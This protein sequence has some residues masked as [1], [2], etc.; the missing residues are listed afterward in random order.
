MGAMA[1]P[2]TVRA[3]ETTTQLTFSVDAALLAELGER[4]VGEPHIALGELI[5]NGYDADATHVRIQFTGDA[6]IVEDDGHGMTFDEFDRLWMRVGSTHKHEQGTSRNRGRAL[7]GSKGVGRL[8]VQFLARRLTLQTCAGEEEVEATVFWPDAARPGAELVKTPVTVTRRPSQ[9]T[10]IDSPTGMRLVLAE[11]N[12]AWMSD[13][14][15]HLAQEIWT[16]QPPFRAAGVTDHFEVTLETGDPMIKAAFDAQLRA[17]LEIWTARLVGHM[18]VADD[19]R[20]QI[21]LTLEFN[22]GTRLRQAYDASAHVDRLDFEIRV[23]NLVQRQPLGIRVGEARGYFNRFGGV[24]VY[25]AGFRLP[26]YGPE[27]DWLGIEQDHSHRLSVSDLLPGDLNVSGGLS[28]L[29]TNSR[30]FGVVNVDTGHERRSAAESGENL[31]IAVTRDRLVANI[32]YRELRTAVRW[33]LDYYAMQEARRRQKAEVA[34]VRAIAPKRARMRD[35]LERHRDAIPMRVFESI[36]TELEETIETQEG[37]VDRATR[38]AGLLGA[39]ATAGIA[40]VGFEHEIS[41]QITLLEEL[42]EDLSATDREVDRHAAAL[43]ILEWVERAR[44]TR[45]IFSFVMDTEQDEPRSMPAAEVCAT[46]IAQMG[47]LLRGI[48]IDQVVPENLR[49]PKGRFAEWAAILQNV[50]INAAN[51]T[52]DVEQPHIRIDGRTGRRGALLIHDNG[53][54][55]D[56]SEAEELFEPFVRRLQLPPERQRSGLGGTGLG[57]TIVRMLATTLNCKVQFVKP[58]DGFTTTLEIS[59]QVA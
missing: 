43:S 28:Y 48:D 57:L 16:L 55:V 58:E 14:F 53:V 49:L 36:S 21:R 38:R 56:L 32:A 39:L 23:F 41:K 6:L 7:T 10:F 20:R 45:R 17:V 46:V 22:D 33:A 51:A 24:H 8:A 26:Y 1:H 25:D 44:A 19:G 37:E 52:L 29:P 30:L 2:T 59:W 3:A 18:H 34:D 4:L 50:L 5:K 54:G 27:T 42:A 47:P 13:D 35:V 15:R 12:H 40:A 11:L 9:R 31:T